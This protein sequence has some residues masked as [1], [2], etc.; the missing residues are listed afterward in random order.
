VQARQ[1]MDSTS[2][3]TT[4]SHPSHRRRRLML[5]R[6]LGSLLGL[7]ADS[8]D[9]GNDD[10]DD[11]DGNDDG[12]DDTSD[13]LDHL[14]TI[15]E[16]DDLLEYL[17]L[18]LGLDGAAAASSAE[19]R[20]VVEF[21]DDVWRYR[22]DGSNK[23][24]GGDADIADN[25][26]S[27]EG[28]EGE[29]VHDDGVATDGTTATP[30]SSWKEQWEND[31]TK[32]KEKEAEITGNR[33][34]SLE[35]V[36]EESQEVHHQRQ[37][38]R[39]QQRRQEGRRQENSEKQVV[40]QTQS[41]KNK[42]IRKEEEVTS[43]GDADGNDETTSRSSN[44]SRNS[45]NKSTKSG[46]SEPSTTNGTTTKSQNHPHQPA[47]AKPIRGTPRIV[48]GCFGMKHK[49]LTNCLRCG[50]I[51]CA[52]EGQR[53]DD[54]DDDDCCTFCAHCGYRIDGEAVI[55]AISATAK[56]NDRDKELV[57]KALL[58]KERLL[59]F[60]REFAQRT[61][62]LDDQADYFGGG[63]NTAGSLWMDEEERADAEEREAER[64]RNLHERKKQVLDIDL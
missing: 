43:R 39:K 53:D 45:K 49:P 21:V 16:R 46:P 60:D 29:G 37:E 30:A 9:Y 3:R 61:V 62:I 22:N 7:D 17:T 38:R 28:D 57:R 55:D 1:R 47:S 32:R 5:Q 2:K 15:T 25:D 19:S 12:N 35:L 51:V 27:G 48:C 23:T 10:N 40:V 44:P 6:Q 42:N 50:R 26:E 58:H 13:V 56:G 14:L 11:D 20:A 24:P 8:S 52:R 54:D 36:D 4:S 41:K 64:R 33:V 18:L 63:G 31:A 34:A 59:K